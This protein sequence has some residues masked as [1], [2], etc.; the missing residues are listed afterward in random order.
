MNTKLI[1]ITLILGLSGC[2]NGTGLPGTLDLQQVNVNGLPLQT[3]T[4]SAIKILSKPLTMDIGAVDGCYP[5]GDAN[6]WDF[7]GIRYYVHKD[8]LYFHELYFDSHYKA[9]QIR[10]KLPGLEVSERT[11][12]SDFRN[13]YSTSMDIEK[14]KDA[15]TILFGIKSSSPCQIAFDFKAGKLWRFAI[16]PR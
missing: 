11:T 13:A 3:D 2:T 16:A 4:A 7:N 5:F 6:L 10:I 8:S 15:T 9:Q 14:Q 1:S 12:L